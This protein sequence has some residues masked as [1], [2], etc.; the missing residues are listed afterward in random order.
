MAVKDALLPEFDQ[1]MAATRRVLERAPEA[2]FGWRPN[3]QSYDLGALATH[4]AQ[5]PRWGMSILKHDAHDLA[6]GTAT[7]TPRT[8]VADVLELFDGHVKDVRAS[9]VELPDGH[10]QAPWALKRGSLLIVSMPRIV[11]I[12]S[13]VLHHTIHHRGQLT[14][15]LKLHDIPLPPLYGP[16]ADE[17]M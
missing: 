8:T 4:L 17:L 6:E 2:A 14:V 9:L 16:T 12:R 5:I 10:L 3:P 11:A 1:E 15:Y 13:F 7:L